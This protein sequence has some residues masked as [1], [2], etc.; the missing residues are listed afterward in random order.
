MT[1]NLL[2]GALVPTGKKMPGIHGL[3]AIAALMVMMPHVWLFS[4]FAGPGFLRPVASLCGFGVHLF[5]VLSAF[6]LFNSTKSERFDHFEYAIKRLFRIAPLFYLVF[7]YFALV[8]KSP[9]FEVVVLNLT[10]LFGLF[11]GAATSGVPGGW[12]VG[13][14]MI[15]Y[16]ALPFILTTCR[17]QAS[18]AILALLGTVVSWASYRYI[19]LADPAAALTFVPYYFISFS[20]NIAPF[21]LGL[22]AFAIY[23]DSIDKRRTAAVSAA[24]TVILLLFLLLTPL[25]DYLRSL[26]RPGALLLFV[27][28][29]SAAVWQAS[30]PSWLMSNALMQYL[31]ERSYSLYLIQ[32]PILMALKPVF[33]KTN[34]VIGPM[35]FFPN[36]ILAVVI[37]S[38]AA[39]VTY[40]LVEV[41]GV[42]LGRRIIEGRRN[43]QLAPAE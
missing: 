14:E 15:F 20:S 19:W 17:T 11:Q 31:G 33:L 24:L 8:G 16:A 6:S 25:R 22:L 40:R 42:N 21:C 23:R 27:A 38:V 9:S 37:V 30:R 43:I 26:N 18:Y 4:G 3:R 10:F 34:S 36:F 28:F 39:S 29:A 41:P 7:I 13:V 12:S 5:F 2:S 35:A 1:Q 32:A